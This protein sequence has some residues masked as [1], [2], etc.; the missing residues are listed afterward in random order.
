M[1]EG[2]QMVARH[3][4]QTDLNRTRDL[5]GSRTRISVTT[6]SSGAAQDSSALDHCSSSSWCLS[7]SS[8]VSWRMYIHA[9]K[10]KS[11]NF[12]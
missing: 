5:T 11:K 2:S 6:I 9:A 8:A 7:S 12:D 10:L 3:A 1:K 4:L